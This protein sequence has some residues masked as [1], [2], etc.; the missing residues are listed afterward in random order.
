[1]R[2]FPVRHVSTDAKSPGTGG[3]AGG[4]ALCECWKLNPGT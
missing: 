3:M 1:M 2:V 4:G